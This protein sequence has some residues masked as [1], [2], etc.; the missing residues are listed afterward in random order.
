METGQ[1]KTV[2]RDH[3][4]LR[5]KNTNPVQSH[6]KKSYIILDPNP[7][8]L[9]TRTLGAFWGLDFSFSWGPP[10]RNE[11]NWGGFH[12]Q[13]SSTSRRKLRR[14]SRL[15]G[16]LRSLHVRGASLR[17]QWLDFWGSSLKE[18]G[19]TKV[20]ESQPMAS[21]RAKWICHGRYCLAQSPRAT[22][23]SPFGATQ[24]WVPRE[25]RSF[26]LIG[27]GMLWAIE[28]V[29]LTDFARATPGRV[30]RLFQL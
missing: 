22:R 29:Q 3:I 2:L 6:K 25:T 15:K 21:L 7:V 13:S 8:Q 1:R 17:P 11:T 5:E 4:R 16:R 30:S 24:K 12:H 9:K 23:R 27:C 19:R 14:R 28:I 26:Q 20:L 18:E 10:K